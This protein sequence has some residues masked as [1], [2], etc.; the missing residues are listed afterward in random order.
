MRGWGEN[1]KGEW[2][3]ERGWW[4]RNSKEMCRWKE[5]EGGSIKDDND[6]RKLWGDKGVLGENN[7]RG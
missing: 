1:I 7:R 4:V 6:K 5:L 3:K 2:D